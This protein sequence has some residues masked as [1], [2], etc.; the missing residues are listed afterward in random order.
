MSKDQIKMTFEKYTVPEYQKIQ[1][2]NY[3]DKKNYV[4]I[5]ENILSFKFKK[6]YKY[7]ES[8]IGSFDKS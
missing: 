8:D 3:H 5:A 6:S 1:T 2:V 7:L 4:Q